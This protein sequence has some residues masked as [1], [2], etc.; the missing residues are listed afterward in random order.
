MADQPGNDRQRLEL[1]ALGGDRNALLQLLERDRHDTEERVRRDT[2]ERMRKEMRQQARLNE[3]MNA[4]LQNDKQRYQMEMA[5][6]IDEM[7]MVEAERDALRCEALAQACR[8][9]MQKHVYYYSCALEHANYISR[10]R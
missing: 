10:K 9:M 4:M 1:Q 3:V 2:E 6:M 8:V 7:K 5:S